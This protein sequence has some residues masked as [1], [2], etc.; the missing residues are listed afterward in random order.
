MWLFDALRKENSSFVN[1]YLQCAAIM[2]GLSALIGCASSGGIQHASPIAIHTP[3]SI[4]F[5][6]VET[7][8][9]LGD[10]EPEKH[11]LNELVISGLRARDVFGDV[12]GDGPAANASGGMDIKIDIKE[13]KKISPEEREWAGALAGRARIM[14]GVTVSELSSGK[15]IETFDAAGES[16]GGSDLAGATDEA[17]QRAAEQVVAQVIKISRQTGP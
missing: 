1:N 14:V 9:A 5:A 12:E 8:S 11:S 17:I 13:I 15:L 4:D 6:R 2:V 16:S 7:S 10:L 3:V